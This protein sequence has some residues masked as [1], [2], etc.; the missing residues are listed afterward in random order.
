MRNTLAEVF[1]DETS[2]AA[3][4]VCIVHHFSELSAFKLAPSFDRAVIHF[5]TAHR[6]SL[7]HSEAATTK[8][9]HVA[10]LSCLMQRREP[11]PELFGSEVK[12]TSH[13]LQIDTAGLALPAPQYLQTVVKDVA[14]KALR[15]RCRFTQLIRRLQQC[16]P[17]LMVAFR[18]S[19]NI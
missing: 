17:S 8:W 4:G 13:V 11:S 1:E 7:K 15:C 6:H 10:E 14:L 9:R 5:Q 12:I 3:S 19:F 2:K 16:D 18:T